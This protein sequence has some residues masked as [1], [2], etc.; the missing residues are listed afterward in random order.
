MFILAQPT[1]STKPRINERSAS[2]ET[3]QGCVVTV[4]KFRPNQAAPSVVHAAKENVSVNVL[5][6]KSESS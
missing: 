5:Y 4:E 6:A 3:R 1:C 2:P